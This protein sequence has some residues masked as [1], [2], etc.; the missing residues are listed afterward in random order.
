MHLNL[1][2]NTSETNR[3]V[4]SVWLMKKFQ[5]LEIR[6]ANDKHG[7]ELP[8]QVSAVF[9]VTFKY[10][11]NVFASYL[12]LDGLGWTD[13]C[14]CNLQSRHCQDCVCLGIHYCDNLYLA[15]HGAMLLPGTHYK[16][17]KIQH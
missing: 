12:H 15:S 8:Q 9:H 17:G 14:C 11:Y 1:Y 10:I 5:V 7:T 2:S 3:S 13:D 16:T 6:I 4:T